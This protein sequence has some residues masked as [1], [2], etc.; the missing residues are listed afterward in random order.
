MSQF[1]IFCPDIPCPLF[2]LNSVYI[3]K[4]KAVF[5]F[6]FRHMHTEFN[7]PNEM[8]TTNPQIHCLSC[9]N[10]SEYV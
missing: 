1:I 9:G 3:F 7:P 6:V 5:L 2:K 4:S 10:I 8:N